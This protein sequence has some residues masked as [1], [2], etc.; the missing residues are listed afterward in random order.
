M[1]FSISRLAKVLGVV[2]AAACLA[3]PVALANSGPAIDSWFR[4]EHGINVVVDDYYRDAPQQITVDDWYRDPVAT[5]APTVVVDDY[6]RDPVT[7]QAP[8]VLPDDYFRDPQPTVVRVPVNGF[9][10]GDFGIGAAASMGA[11]LLLLGLAAGALAAR[12]SHQTE[13]AATV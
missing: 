7:R 5:Q 3:A 11:L 12:R 9:D 6:F 8:Q 4:E 10:W 1:A 2:V 13:P